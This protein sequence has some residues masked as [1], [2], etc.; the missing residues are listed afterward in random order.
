MPIVKILPDGKVRIVNT[1]SGEVKDV[2]PKDLTSYAPRLVDDY[3]KLLTAGEVSGSGIPIKDVQ[4]GDPVKLALQAQ[5]AQ[6]GQIA[7]VVDDATKAKMTSVQQALDILKPNLAQAEVTGPIMGN[8]ALLANKVTGGGAAPEIADYEALRK[9]LIGPLARAIS[10]EVGVLTDRD[11]AR[12]EGLLPK[13]SDAK[14]VR[15][16]KLKNLQDLINIK[17]GK[18]SAGNDVNSYLDKYFPKK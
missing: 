4:T 2:D 16:N 1:K 17:S 7:P 5:Q 3:Q 12:A 14:K 6:S 18:Q 10:G 9:S 8:L 13:I 15:E 11:I